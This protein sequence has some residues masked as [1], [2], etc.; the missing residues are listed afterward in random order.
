MVLLLSGVFFFA[1]VPAETKALRPGMHDKIWGQ[2]PQKKRPENC[3][4]RSFT[5]TKKKLGV[6]AVEFH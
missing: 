4:K 5:Y 6:N 3:N 1:P 2:E